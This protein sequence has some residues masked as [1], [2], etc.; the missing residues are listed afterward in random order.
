MLRLPPSAFDNDRATWATVRA[1]IY[2]LRGDA[3]H[4]RIYA[5]SARLGYLDQ[6]KATPN[7]AQIHVLLGLTLAWLGRKDE[8]I[9]E[10]QRGVALRPTTV[11]A[12]NGAYYLHQLVRIYIRTGETDKAIDGIETLRRLR[13]FISP[14]SPDRSG[15]RSAPGNPRFQKLVGG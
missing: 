12:V 5:D 14:G 4:T 1:Q 11:D 9:A 13:Y 8:A 2:A 6:L 3:V 15:V 7:D 10:G